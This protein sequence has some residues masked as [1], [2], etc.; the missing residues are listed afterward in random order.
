MAE[1]RM[2][3][4]SISI[5]EKV[6]LLPDMFD[7]LLFTWLIPHTDDFGRLTGSPAKVKALVV[8]MLDKSIKDVD[9]SLTELHKADLIEWYEI[10]GNKYIQIVNFERHQTGLHKRTLS[11]IPECPGDSRK[12]PEIPPQGKGR[13][14]NL[15]E[16]N[17]TEGKGTSAPSDQNGHK[18]RIMALC[19][20]MKIQG[21]TL[22]TLDIVYSYIGMADIE[23]IEAAIKKSQNKPQ[24]Y[25][26]N[27]LNGMIINDKITRAEQLLP[28]RGGR[29]AEHGGGTEGVRSRGTS[30]AGT[31][32][33]EGE[34]KDYG[35]IWDDDSPMSEVSG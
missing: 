1:K 26:T 9:R 33:H 32:R 19:N 3:S 15:T 18:E 22:Y 30:N 5:S 25:L 27:T 8:P 24:T 34:S 17:R 29:N 7:M 16:G 21:F 35:S 13:E 28:A 2:V 12:F 10:D 20:E 4:K 23:V 11:K 14:E 6:N 31:S